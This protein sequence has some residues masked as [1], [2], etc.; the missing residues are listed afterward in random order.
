MGKYFVFTLWAFP[1]NETLWK[2]ALSCTPLDHLV[3]VLPFYFTRHI[4][5]HKY[6]ENEK[7]VTYS[8][9]SYY[10]HPS[11]GILCVRWTVKRRLLPEPGI[12]WIWW[13]LIR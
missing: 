11:P 4:D 6:H 13:S 8:Y 5:S 10:N 12:R 9:P 7:E 2:I 3:I 1:S